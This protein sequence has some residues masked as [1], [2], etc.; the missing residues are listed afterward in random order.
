MKP[1]DLSYYT[2]EN[3]GCHDLAYGLCIMMRAIVSIF[4][5][6]VILYVFIVVL[7]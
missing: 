5:L 1:D 4:S 3:G 6:L 2:N 7:G